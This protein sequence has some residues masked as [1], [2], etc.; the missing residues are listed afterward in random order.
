VDV[1]RADEAQCLT[2]TA[3]DEPVNRIACELVEL[4]SLGETSL[5]TL[6]PQ[7]LPGQRLTLNLSSAHLRT[8]KAE[9][10]SKVVVNLP[11]QGVHIMPQRD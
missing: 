5:C 3:S 1:G 4:L 10:G 2:P 11:A 7:A 6:V 9:V 8:L